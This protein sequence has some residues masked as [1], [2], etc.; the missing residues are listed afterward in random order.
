[1]LNIVLFGPPGAGKGTQ[2]EK[3]IEQYNLMHLSTGDILRAEKKAGSPLGKKAQEYSEKGLLVPDE[4]VIALIEDKIKSN[5]QVNGFIFDGFPRTVAQ[6]K[7]LDV[8][9]NTLSIPV[10]GMVA[11][12]VKEDELFT[13]LIKR[14]ET[15]D[16]PDDKD[17]VIIKQR[18]SVYNN[19]TTPV[20]GFYSEQK[21]YYGVDGMLSI[22]EVFSLISNIVDTL[23]NK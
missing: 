4:L 21:K 23:K 22:D 8:M 14:G 9:L 15:S 5:K 2:S 18:I 17:P 16:R 20:A 7:A 6:A 11:L 12:E 3:L 10:S 19:E 1:M 13:R